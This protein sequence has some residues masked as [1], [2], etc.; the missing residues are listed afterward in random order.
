MSKSCIFTL[1]KICDNCGAC[2]ICDLNSKKICNNCGKC[3]E[4]ANNDYKEVIIDEIDDIN[5]SDNNFY[6]HNNDLTI[7]NLEKWELG[8]DDT[9]YEDELDIEYIDDVE[10]LRELLDTPEN[11]TL[12]EVFPG[13]YTIKRDKKDCIH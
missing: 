8:E 6:V 4:T 1:N 13:F 12:E 7:E 5:I 9:S 3:L 2:N 11:D 10:G